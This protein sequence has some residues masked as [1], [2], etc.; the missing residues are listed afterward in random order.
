MTLH[1]LGACTHANKS[2]VP[3]GI[4]TDLLASGAFHDV[5]CGVCARIPTYLSGGRTAFAQL[6]SRRQSLYVTC[7]RTFLCTGTFAHRFVLR[8]STGYVPVSVSSGKPEQ[9]DIGTA[10]YGC[11]WAFDNSAVLA[12][13]TA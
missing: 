1:T 10:V 11:S 8:I 7:A 12:P 13:S 5:D 6:P 9:Q 3:P 4:R 2:A